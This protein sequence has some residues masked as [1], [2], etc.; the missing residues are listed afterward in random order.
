MSQRINYHDRTPLHFAAADNDLEAVRKLMA[1]GANPLVEDKISYSPLALAMANQNE[2]MQAIML[3]VPYLSR[4]TLSAPG[5]L[6]GYYSAVVQIIKPGHVEAVRQCISLGLIDATFILTYDKLSPLYLTIL[7]DV[8]DIF[9][10]FMETINRQNIQIAGLDN[11]ISLA[12]KHRRKEMLKVLIGAGT[13]PV[14]LLVEAA[15]N[16]DLKSALVLIDAGADV[17]AI[18]TKGVKCTALMMA[19]AYNH[20]HVVRALLAAGANPDGKPDNDSWCAITEASSAGRIEVVGLLLEAGATIYMGTLIKTLANKHTDVMHMLLDHLAKKTTTK[21]LLD[22]IKDIASLQRG[23]D[24]LV[25]Y[26][27]EKLFP[28]TLALDAVWDS[29]KSK[30]FKLLSPPLMQK[31]IDC[32]FAAD[33]NVEDSYQ[34]HEICELALDSP[35]QSLRAMLLS[36]ENKD[37][38]QKSRNE[39]LQK[40]RDMKARLEYDYAPF[41]PRYKDAPLHPLAA[42]VFASPA[43]N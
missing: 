11:Y 2:V 24:A 5:K 3:D 43:M 18:S 39:I 4:A 37:V 28:L 7:H 25:K 38:S 22:A 42:D 30:S 26:Y 19:S 15:K 13:N 20:V 1:A 23:N 17:N 16:G 32:L 10:L 14:N 29:Y 9:S 34:Q 8:P 33:A 27:L 36:S 35:Q 40:Y 6:L 12:L 41:P 21:N 31:I